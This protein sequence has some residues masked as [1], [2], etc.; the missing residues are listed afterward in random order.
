[1]KETILCRC[2][3]GGFFWF[4][5]DRSRRP[6]AIFSSKSGVL[7]CVQCDHFGLA[8]M[9]EVYHSMMHNPAEIRVFHDRESALQWLEKECVGPNPSP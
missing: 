7:S 6:P 4:M 1:M 3:H 8:R 9:F 2:R 5:G